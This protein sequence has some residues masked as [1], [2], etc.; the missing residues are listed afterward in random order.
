[1]QPLL[2]YLLAGLS[3]S[4]AAAALYI[5]G[6][7]GPGSAHAWL[8]GLALSRV[9]TGADAALAGMEGQ[10]SGDGSLLGLIGGLMTPDSSAGALLA[11][12]GLLALAPR[13]ESRLG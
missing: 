13:V 4:L 5:A 7:A 10:A 2:S 1:M 9:Q 6:R 12:Y 11:L 3:A 8:Q